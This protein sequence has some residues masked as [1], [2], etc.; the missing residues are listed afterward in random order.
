MIERKFVSEAVKRL[1]AKE[2]IMKELE[3]AG[4]VDVDIQRTTLNTRIGIIAERPGLVIGKK[5][6]S[7]KDLSDAIEKNLGIENPQIEVVDVS[8]P[9]LEPAVM[10]RMIKKSIERGIKA[11]RIMKIAAAK[12]MGAG[13]MGV[14]IIV[15]GTPSKGA[16]SKKDRIVE[17]YIKKAGDSVKFIKETKEQALL[18]QGIIG[19]TV[20]IVPPEVVFPDKII[21]NKPTGIAEIAA[22]T[23]PLPA[24]IKTAEQAKETNLEKIVEEVKPTKEEK[25]AA[26]EV[27][28]EAVDNSKEIKKKEELKCKECGKTFKTQRG[29]IAHEKIHKS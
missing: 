26:K 11:K 24:E 22:E 4:I 5:G 13:A 9:N 6:T 16:I 27:I 19:I 12:I 25:E 20:R 18:K 8:R 29:L 10:A 15:E 21:I 17:G 7:I 14:E 1:R 3:K 28:K 2:Y 23:T